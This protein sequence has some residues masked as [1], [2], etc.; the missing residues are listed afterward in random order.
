MR[1]LVP[2]VQFKK[3]EKH[4]WRSVT[5][6]K[7]ADFLPAY[8]KSGTRDLGSIFGTQDWRPGTW[9]PSP[10]TKDL[11]PHMWDPIQ[12]TN[13]WD[14]SKKTHLVYQSPVFRI[15]LILIYSLEFTSQ[16]LIIAK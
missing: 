3:R 1:H 10:G 16:F 8:R 2:F 5:F 6:S 7:I 13:T 14:Q 12:G 9:D 15:V 4:P 11:G